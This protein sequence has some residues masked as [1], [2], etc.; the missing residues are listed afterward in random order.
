[1]LITKLIIL[2]DYYYYYYLTH[3][4]IKNTNKKRETQLMLLLTCYLDIFIYINNSTQAI[5]IMYCFVEIEFS[6]YNNKFTWIRWLD[7]FFHILNI[8]IDRVFIFENFSNI[9]NIYHY[10]LNINSQYLLSLKLY[11]I[12]VESRKKVV[13]T[14][15]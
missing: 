1:M 9:S 7:F 12:I 5:I 2:S 3:Y 11:I 6:D 13:V 8:S 4:N 15:Y 10:I 14:K